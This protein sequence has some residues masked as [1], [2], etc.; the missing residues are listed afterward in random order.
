LLIS[1]FAVFPDENARESSLA[2]AEK[3][4]QTT[5]SMGADF[6]S[7]DGDSGVLRIR[8]YQ[9]GTYSL[10]PP[11][12]Q[13]SSIATVLTPRTTGPSD[14][15]RNLAPIDC[16]LLTSSEISEVEKAEKAIIEALNR[17]DGSFAQLKLKLD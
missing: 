8:V 4:Y 7:C 14:N 5:L 11:I 9:S 1:F 15:A 17:V 6:V 3:M 16:S 13:S 10:D 12:V 2:F